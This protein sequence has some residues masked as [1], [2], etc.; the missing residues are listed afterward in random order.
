MKGDAKKTS[1]DCSRARTAHERELAL[2]V[3][4]NEPAIETML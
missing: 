2:G 3:D 4:E 1:D